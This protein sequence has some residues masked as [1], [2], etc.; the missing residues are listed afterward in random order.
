MA[1]DRA[2]LL[3]LAVTLVV[4]VGAGVALGTGLVQ[5]SQTIEASTSPSAEPSASV[6]A[7][8][9]ATPD[10]S[11]SA[12]PGAAP[13]P[14]STE[15]AGRVLHAAADGL[16][17]RTEPSASGEIV[18]TLHVGQRMGFVS[19][20]VVA[21]EM[22]WY[23]VAIGF[24]G[25]EGWIASGP[26]G[27]W[28]RLVGDGAIA[29]RCDG[30]GSE[31]F[32]AVTPFGDADLRGIA[33]AGLRDWAWSPDGR[34][35]TGTVDDGG[36]TPATV[37]VFDADGSNPRW[38]GQGYGPRWS[39]DGSRLAWSRGNAIVVTDDTL[40]PVEL[41]LDLLRPSLSFWSPDGTRLA[42]AALDCPAC[43][44]DEQIIGDV[45]SALYVVGTDGS[46]LVKLSG[47]NHDGWTSWSADGSEL[48]L[49]RHDLSGE[50]PTRA[51]TVAADGGQPS[52]ILEGAA[53]LSG[54]QWSPDG[55]QVTYATEEG[56]VVR[57]ADGTGESTTILA[58]D[59]TQV[60]ELRWSPSGT[61]LVYGTSGADG[62][63]TLWIVPAD[64]SDASRRIAPSGA[65]ALQADWQPLLVE[66]P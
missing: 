11:A 37:V 38:L 7:E 46:N 52:E 15:V 22:D 32:V 61:Y 42:I 8:A 57:L 60:T 10:P 19:G 23:E 47:Q 30:C 3:L 14:P 28:V 36:E 35:L 56:I 2:P 24:R 59:A 51:M 44:P 26:N 54:L 43:R 41:G 29:F 58:P 12:T 13:S 6:V 53:V 17:L 5:L 49:I 63:S 33:V 50:F 45:P 31:S 34:R 62:R 4:I 40:V 1:R 64:G 27:D 18:A 25:I 48:S 16:R 55:R 66:L 9:S 20:P 65:T 39:P 21:D